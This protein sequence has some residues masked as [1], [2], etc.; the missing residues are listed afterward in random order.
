MYFEGIILKSA[1]VPSWFPLL[2]SSENKNHFIHQALMFDNA[3]TTSNGP[4]SMTQ[5]L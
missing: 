1:Q 4:I 3:P 5:L 2:I